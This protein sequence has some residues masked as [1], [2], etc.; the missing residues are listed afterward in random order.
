ML[1][2][3]LAVG[4]SSRCPNIEGFCTQ[5]F[6]GEADTDGS[7]AKYTQFVLNEFSKCCFLSSAIV[8]KF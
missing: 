8:F 6:T 2:Y 5:R 1:F 3:H 4:A 7:T